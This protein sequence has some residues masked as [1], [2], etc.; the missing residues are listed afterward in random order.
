MSAVQ[1][2]ADG[3]FPV[4]HDIG[5]P[6]TPGTTE[7]DPS[8][9]AYTVTGSGADIWTGGDQFQF[10]YKE[11]AGDYFILIAHAAEKQ[12]APGSRWGKVGIM[13][14][15]DCTN[16]C[17]YAMM[18]IHG[19]APQDQD[20]FAARPTYGAGDNFEQTALA[21]AQHRDWMRLD[22]DGSVFTGYFSVDGT[23]WERQGSVDLGPTAPAQVL[24]GLAVCG[25]VGCPTSTIVFDQVQLLSERNHAPVICIETDPSPATAFFANGK[26]EIILDASCSTDGDQGTQ[27]LSYLWAKQSGPAGAVIE[28]KTS[29]VTKVTFTATGTYK[30]R[31]TVRDDGLTDS[32]SS[33]TV[34]VTVTDQVQKPLFRRGDA[35][36][37]GKLDLTD[38][39]FTLQFQ[40]MGGRAP[41]CYD[42]ADADDSGALDLT[43]AIYSLQFQFM[44]GKAPPAP[45]PK[46]CGYDTTP[47]GA[48]QKPFPDCVYSKCP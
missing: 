21:A 35:D 3:L 48:G 5:S 11:Q 41:D 17:P 38:A 12:W 25:H 2:L 1:E 36:G 39:I 19:A 4:A 45:G 24:L 16:F 10:A 37:S 6:C 29:A 7:Y 13:A 33:G 8:M 9:D 44:G 23:N 26:A 31:L 40:F 43:D 34:E 14:R 30:F 42:A 27:P 18:Q 28:A 47:Q 15:E 46:D 20:R 32:N 22:R